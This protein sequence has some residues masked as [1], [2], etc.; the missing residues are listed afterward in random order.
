M[1]AKLNLRLFHA[2]SWISAH[3]AA[4]RANSALTLGLMQAHSQQQQLSDTA[5][6]YLYLPMQLVP[7]VYNSVAGST[8]SSQP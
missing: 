2:D 8:G 5:I 3:V 4:Y 6:P 1:H 7:D